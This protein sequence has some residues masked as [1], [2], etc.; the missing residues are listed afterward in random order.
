MAAGAAEGAAIDRGL[1]VAQGDV[2]V[3]KFNV[4]ATNAS[5]DARYQAAHDLSSR[6]MD[7]QNQLG[8]KEADHIFSVGLQGEKQEDAIETLAKEHQNA[9]ALQRQK[10]EEQMNQ[11]ALKYTNSRVLE[12][13]KGET[14]LYNNYLDTYGAIASSD[15]VDKGTQ[16]SNLWIQVGEAVRAN[17]DYQNI[18]ISG[19]G[20]PGYSVTGI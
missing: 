18:T 5:E 20:A 11:D 7:F 13:L 19:P 12:L 14:A 17:S 9:T 1:Q 15:V 3:D 4:G 6:T 2:D 10:Y 8:G 16:L